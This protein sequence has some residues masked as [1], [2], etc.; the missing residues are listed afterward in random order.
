MEYWLAL[1]DGGQETR[2]Y[3]EKVILIRLLYW[4]KVCHVHYLF[5]FHDLQRARTVRHRNTQY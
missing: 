1:A 5:N 3:F 4:Y 2:N